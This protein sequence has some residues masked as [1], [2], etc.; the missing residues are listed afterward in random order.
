MS[1]L[2]R[3]NT[4]EPRLRW[5]D[6][7][8]HRGAALMP[9]LAGVLVAILGPS[10]PALAQDAAGTSSASVVTLL[11]VGLLTALPL[12]FMATTSFVKSCR[13][14]HC[15]WSHGGAGLL[16]VWRTR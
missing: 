11:S 16:A 15:I 10:S 8:E 3:V 9:V 5:L 6:G 12:I 1:P 2:G 13:F 7:L 4:A 14:C